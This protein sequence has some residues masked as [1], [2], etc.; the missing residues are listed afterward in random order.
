M[1]VTTSEVLDFLDHH[2]SLSI[3]RHETYS[4]AFSTLRRGIRSIVV[5]LSEADEMDS[6]ELLGSLRTHLA[7]WLTVPVP[8]DDTIA[9]AISALGDPDTVERRWGRE[10]RTAYDAAYG[11]AVQ[12]QGT[13]ILFAGNSAKGFK[14]SERSGQSGRSIV[15]GG[16]ESTLSRSLNLNRWRLIGFCIHSETIERRSRSTY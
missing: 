9:E 5:R 16:R 11:A 13:E 7:E 15:I 6:Q 3:E 14:S 2:P 10:I 1:A 4:A 12:I 8:F